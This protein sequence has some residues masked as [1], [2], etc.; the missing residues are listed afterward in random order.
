LASSASSTSSALEE[1]IHEAEVDL[2]YALHCPL[3]QKYISLYKS[4]DEKNG[5]RGSPNDQERLEK[6]PLWKEVETRMV[7]GTLQELRNSRSKAVEPPTKTKLI[8]TKY[9][10]DSAEGART[11]KKSHPKE[12]SIWKEKGS[13]S[14]D[15][16][17]DGGFFDE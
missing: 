14:P 16:A 9:N 1:R 4:K 2:N 12:R 10:N 7:N 5:K 3:D 8:P 13:P 17:S 6:P 11:S 15:N